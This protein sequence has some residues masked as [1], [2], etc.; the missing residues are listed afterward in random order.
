MVAQ[1][2]I[3]VGRRRVKVDDKNESLKEENKKFNSSR[4]KYAHQLAK[5]IF[6]LISRDP[7][8]DD[9]SFEYIINYILDIDNN[10]YIGKAP[11]ETMSQEEIEEIFENKNSLE[12]YFLRF[13]AGTLA[14]LG[15]RIEKIL[16]DK[17]HRYDYVMIS[18]DKDES[19]AKD[20]K[21]ASKQLKQEKIK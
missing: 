21:R 6:G 3:K 18:D 16:G 5:N 12:N 15:I 14:R 2:E 20:L 7:Q 1:V 8:Q 11:Y 17:F 10:H 13:D 4:D 9:G 19:M